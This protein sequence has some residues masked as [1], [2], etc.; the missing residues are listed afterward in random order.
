MALDGRVAPKK[1]KKKKKVGAG[2]PPPSPMA[3]IASTDAG[4]KLADEY[5]EKQ[6]K[7]LAHKKKQAAKRRF[8]AAAKKYNASIRV[9]SPVSGG[10]STLHG[11]LIVEAHRER[12]STL[13]KGSV[14]SPTSGGASSVVGQ[15]QLLR[16]REYGVKVTGRLDEATQAAANAYRAAYRSGEYKRRPPPDVGVL[17]AQADTVRAAWATFGSVFGG[18]P[19]VTMESL[20]LQRAREADARKSAL[21]VKQQLAMERKSQQ[22]AL[23]QVR[24]RKI[25]SGKNVPLTT[26]ELRMHLFDP[27][28]GVWGSGSK[29]TAK[30][31]AADKGTVRIIQT[32]LA[33]QGY[34]NVPQSGEF[35]WKTYTALRFAFKQA[36]R[37]EQ[38]QR[39][40]AITDAF[41]ANGVVSKDRG[42]PGLGYVGPK[43]LLGRL[44]A[45]GPG[46]RDLMTWLIREA[47]RKG[48]QSYLGVARSGTV[49]AMMSAAFGAASRGAAVGT[50]GS[51]DRDEDDSF[52]TRTFGHVVG[53]ALRALDWAGDE[54]K[55]SALNTWRHGIFQTPS[56]ELEHRSEA[57]ETIRKFQ[58]EHPWGDFALDVVSDPLNFALGAG[59][60]VRAP[61]RLAGRFGESARRAAEAGLRIA[62]DGRVAGID[63]NGPS[64]FAFRVPA[65]GMK[66]AERAMEVVWRGVAEDAMMAPSVAQGLYLLR[67]ATAMKTEVVRLA[68]ERAEQ[69]VARGLEVYEP[70]AASVPGFAQAKP[71][72]NWVPDTS[73]KVSAPLR[74]E[75]KEVHAAFTDLVGAQGE[76]LINELSRTGTSLYANKNV[77]ELSVPGG[78]YLAEMMSWGRAL[79]ARHLAHLDA[80]AVVRNHLEE[81]IVLR[82][83][84]AAQA[85]LYRAEYDR[86]LGEVDLFFAGTGDPALMRRVER[87][88]AGFSD[89]LRVEL[90][91]ALQR[92]IMAR[93]PHERLWDDAGDWTGVGGSVEREFIEG[94]RAHFAD[95]QWRTRP[96][97]NYKKEFDK[98]TYHYLRGVELSHTVGRL[99]SQKRIRLASGRALTER[100]HQNL[101]ANAER[102]VAQSW[103]RVRPGVWVDQRKTLSVPV[104]YARH[105][106]EIYGIQGGAISRVAVALPEM[107]VH[108]PTLIETG[109]VVMDGLAKLGRF[110]FSSIREWPTFRLSV[111]DMPAAL[112]NAT[113]PATLNESQDFKEFVRAARDLRRVSGEVYTAALAQELAKDGALWQALRHS[114]GRWARTLYLSMSSSLG[115]WRFMTLPLRPGWVLRN[116]LDNAAKTLLAGV[117]DPRLWLMGAENPGSGLRSIFEIGIVPLREGARFLG[118]LFGQGDQV[119]EQFEQILRMTFWAQPARVISRVFGHLDIPAPEEWIEM[120]RYAK[121]AMETTAPRWHP[122][123]KGKIVPGVL[124]DR[125][126]ADIRR[127]MVED[128]VDPTFVER[129]LATLAKWHDFIWDV[130]GSRPENYF[131]RVIYR[132]VYR[133]EMRKH[134]DVL[135]ATRKAWGEVER[136]LF[137]YSKITVIEDNFRFFFPFIQFWRKNST[138]WVNVGTVRQPWFFYDVY[139]YEQAFQ[140]WREELN[141]VD[142]R[143]VSLKEVGDLLG[144]VPGLDWLGRQVSELR[145]DPLN[146]L[147]FATLYRSFKGESPDLPP[148]RAGMEFIGGFVDGLN[149]LGLSANPLLRKP[150]EAAGVLSFRAWQSIFPQTKLLETFT[151]SFWESRFP[152]GL[153]LEAALLDPVLSTLGFE[154]INELTLESFNYQVQ[155]EMAGQMLRGETVSRVVAEKK[156]RDYLLVQQTIGYFVGIY[157]NRATPEDLL[158]RDLGYGMATG[159][160]DYMTDLTP[161]ERVAY[162]LWKRKGWDP[163]FYD[164]YVQQIPK[165][166]LYF[167]LSW[168]EGQ[169][170]LQEHP[171]ILPF[172]R[173]KWYGMRP[174]SGPGYMQAHSLV[175]ETDR[176][177]ALYDLVRAGDLPRS[178][179]RLAY[180]LLVTPELEEF[181]KLNDTTEDVRRAMLRGEYYKYLIG[182]QKTYAMLP[183]GD[184]RQSYVERHPELARWWQ[185]LASESD[186]L[187]TVMNASGAAL[188]E[189]YF[190][191]VGKKDYDGMTKFVLRF[192]WIFEGTKKAKKYREVVRLGHFP[193]FVAFG[194]GGWGGGGG[195][196]SQYAKDYLSAKK[197]LDK[198]FDMP[199][200]QRYKWLD[201][202]GE[203]AKKVKWFFDKYAKNK[204]GKARSEKARDYLASKRW[205]DYY[206]AMGDEERVAW[207]NGGSRGAQVVKWFFSKYAK[208]GSGPKAQSQKA[209]DYLAAKKWLD[210]YFGLAKEERG[211]WLRSGAEGAAMVLA[212]FEKY[213]KVGTATEQGE[214]YEAAKDA[215]AAYWALPPGDRRAWLES[216]SPQARLVK[217]YFEKYADEKGESKRREDYE[218]VKQYLEFYYALPK[219]RRAAWL[220]GNTTPALAVKWYFDKYFE[221]NNQEKAW[222]NNDPEWLRAQYKVRRLRREAERLRRRR[223]GSGDGTGDLGGWLDPDTPDEDWVLAE[224]PSLRKRLQF[225]RLYFALPPDER[226][227]F[228]AE[229]A[230]EYGV[231]I[232]GYLGE[233]AVADEMEAWYQQMLALGVDDGR[234]QLYAYA[235]PLLT[236][237]FETLEDPAER[238]MFRR[239]NP[240]LDAYL[241]VY[242]E[243]PS[244]GD[245]T[246]DALLAEY[247]SLPRGSAAREFLLAE[248]PELAEWF[249]GDT[250]AQDDAMNTLLET[251]FSLGPRQRKRFAL[252]HPEIKNHFDARRDQQRLERDQLRAFDNAD[253]RFAPFVEQANAEMGRA[254][255][256]KMVQMLA[257][258]AEPYLIEY[259]RGRREL[260]DLGVSTRR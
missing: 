233:Q 257:R 25:L 180:N 109:D 120:A 165:I 212:F 240:Q 22:R 69:A 145:F 176:A 132:G 46:A 214:A 134:G 121:E 5:R 107:G 33:S 37:A 256:L 114:Q 108:V 232:Y 19:K 40:V 197:W 9:P 30:Q 122:R 211:P 64:R 187:R 90:F 125:V 73:I 99:V 258:Q 47:Q 204:S 92:Q 59:V 213:A 82:G 255:Y 97:P 100:E 117:V 207:L 51:Y 41:Y 78:Q 67:K 118:R 231:F 68:K 236:F 105:L 157:T 138:Y 50:V 182:L 72:G 21:T 174:G 155:R 94:G 259:R 36:A 119:A 42:I 196:Q 111:D 57:L 243:R 188:R 91:P 160:I 16:A 150:L 34:V 250:D 116:T 2:G 53:P 49:S 43:D 96:N 159:E 102:K 15:Q 76:D 189:R 20:R 192:P 167:R 254:Q 244:T 169:R 238:E 74:K 206:F 223:G 156:I 86:V 237:Y 194:S 48:M 128:G 60:W 44:N 218:A 200:A 220:R 198:Y 28:F 88:M 61:M 181:W 135:E 106:P 13:G 203:G 251:Y 80:Q 143:Y 210:L 52:F 229:H 201:A 29:L 87:M 177:I 32:Y 14:P 252:D 253:P 23:E 186:D 199:K 12:Q 89:Y 137:D 242:S 166:Q 146:L 45:G 162:T 184:Q 170:Y 7:A 129:N 133:R 65:Y 185:D 140:H 149:D 31:K 123:N 26:H 38:K 131:K 178:I 249:R 205:L 112:R 216:D 75:H 77:G 18:A 4:K 17:V 190:E 6:A 217:A 248:Q 147:S 183:E 8:K 139:H 195:G 84:M 130:A 241:D 27:E 246:L 173:D 24:I 221:Q 154:T 168:L 179:E 151:R 225:W 141:P 148:D 161:D 35:D 110:G 55:A 85:R 126:P 93:V 70:P 171:E 226:P 127:M 104:A 101:V 124:V 222:T 208:H 260:T 193:G 247:Y 239:A 172:V 3:G 136:A 58:D 54:I 62:D 81:G 83:D 191:L 39:V 235:K 227:A 115:T 95:D 71:Q 175:A 152:N 158:F 234:S 228:V 79:A 56:Q 163:V 11:Q 142:R 209:K 219:D 230:D 1:K 202:G 164:H 215:L 245:E 63:L 224:N 113:M 10:A 103:K 66:G 98:E 144:R 153:N